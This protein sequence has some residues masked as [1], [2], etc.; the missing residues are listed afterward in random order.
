MRQLGLGLGYRRGITN[1]LSCATCQI[2][3]LRELLI[4]YC[5]STNKP[6][7]IITSATVENST[8]RTTATPSAT[9]F[10]LLT[11]TPTGTPTLPTGTFQLPI[12]APFAVNNTCVSDVSQADT[13]SCVIQEDTSYQMHVRKQ[14]GGAYYL[15]LGQGNSTLSTLT[16]GMQEPV[17]NFT[18][19]GVVATDLDEPSSGPS[20]LFQAIFDK[21]VILPDAALSPAR[22]KARGF[23]GPDIIPKRQNTAVQAGD[24]PW[25]CYWN[26]TVLEVSIYANLTSLPTS[27]SAVDATKT[28][29]STSSSSDSVVQPSYPKAVKIEDTDINPIV[30]SYC[31]QYEIQSDGSKTP[32]VSSSGAVVSIPISITSSRTNNCRCVWLVN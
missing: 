6:S 10:S 3:V 15:S 32:V 14:A 30:S 17:T 11:T 20:Y 9:D 19:A 27:T 28:S 31:V 12:P 21:I 22:I 13:W 16:Y 7:S 25:F 23:R 4:L 1:L 29:T 18:S 2:K 8:I 24:M 26:S 5:C